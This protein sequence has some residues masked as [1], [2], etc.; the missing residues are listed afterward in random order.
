VEPE[1]TRSIVCAGRALYKFIV[2][3]RLASLTLRGCDGPSIPEICHRKHFLPQT[4]LLKLGRDLPQRLG[5]VP[6]LLRR[7]EL[8]VTHRGRLVLGTALAPPAAGEET[9]DSPTSLL[10]PLP[11]P[12]WYP[13][14]I[15]RVHK[16]DQAS[17]SRRGWNVCT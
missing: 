16:N 7:F 1:V 14:G 11:L 12:R 6:K 9:C 4:I 5:F 17:V 13:D 2:R 8:A 15:R 3:H 10:Q